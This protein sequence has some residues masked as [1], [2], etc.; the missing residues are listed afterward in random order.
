M[1]RHTFPNGSELAHLREDLEA[2]AARLARLGGRAAG[3]TRRRASADVETL[4][5]AVHEL[6]DR[7][8]GRGR[9]I[10]GRVNETVQEHPFAVLATAFAAGALL[11]IALRRGN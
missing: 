5:D 9:E 10:G 11:G 7:I 8:G 4:Q 2:L 6:M 1:A 3:D